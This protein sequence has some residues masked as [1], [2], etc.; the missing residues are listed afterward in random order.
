MSRKY[1]LSNLP[2]ITGG[3]EKPPTDGDKVDKAEHERV[4]AEGERAK[5]DATRRE[6]LLRAAQKKN[7]ELEEEVMTPIL[8]SLGLELPE[9]PEE[10]KQ[11][12]AAFI[13]QQQKTKKGKALPEEEVQ[14]LLGERDKKHTKDLEVREKKSTSYRTKL[15]EVLIREEALK[16][17]IEL[18]ATEAGA[19]AIQMIVERE[20][21]LLEEEDGELKAVIKGKDGPKLNR[22]G[23]HM[24]IR[25]RVNE[26]AAEKKYESYFRAGRSGSGSPGGGIGSGVGSGTRK[27]ITSAELEKLSMAEYEQIDKQI[28][29]GEVE[30]VQ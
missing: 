19:E 1:D 22:D 25:D 16:A 7:K 3:E 8:T 27:R 20:A 13:D 30:L 4:K 5:A 26:I 24:A 15:R 17:A 14:R 21:D 28:K 2:P 10:R 18:G 29:S 12:V 23:A 11:A 9:D 6:T